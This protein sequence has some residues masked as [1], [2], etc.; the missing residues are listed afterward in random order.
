M[1]FCGLPDH[2]DGSYCGLQPTAKVDGTRQHLTQTGGKQRNPL[3]PAPAGI[4]LVVHP[5][6]VGTICD[7]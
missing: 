2:S 5:G 4:G 7:K 1:T 3:V 6:P